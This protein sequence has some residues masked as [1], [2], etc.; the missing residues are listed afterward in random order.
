M[1]IKT[2]Y[3]AAAINRYPQAA[4]I[5]EASFAVFG[6]S[7]LVALWNIADE[8]G[9]G[10]EETLP[11]HEGLVTCIRFMSD[12]M[13]ASADDKGTLIS[14]RKLGSQWKSTGRIQ[15]HTKAISSLCVFNDWVITGSSDA[16]IRIWEVTST[17]ND[18][19][20]FVEFQT[21]PFQGKY[22]LSMSLTYLPQ[23]KVAILAI[24][25][26]GNSV[27]IWA[28]SD[29]QFVH[30]AV[31]TGH[32]DWVRGLA[33]L[34]PIAAGQPLV[35]AS[36]SQDATIRLWAFEPWIA[37]TSTRLSHPTETR[38]DDLL[39]AFEAS[40]GE[41]GDTEEGGRQISLRRHIITVKEAQRRFQR[42][43]ITFDA[44]LVGHE[45]GVTSLSWRPPSPFASVPTLLS[46]STDSS[47]IMWSPSTA[48][49]GSD[50][51]A[52]IWTN[53]QRFGDV[54][55]QR[56]GGFVGGVWNPQGDEILAWGWAGGWRRWR[57]CTSSKSPDQESW[58]E[59]ETISGHSGPVKS[60]GW[61]PDGRY[62]ISTG[63]DQST[64][65]HAPVL[66]GARVKPVWHEISRPQVHGYDML[67][68]VFIDPFKFVSIADE[69]VARVFEAP[70]GFMRLADS[71]GVSKM[72]DDEHFRPLGASVPPLGLSNKATEEGTLQTVIPEVPFGRRPFEGELASFTL[73]PETEKIFGHGY[74]S[75]TLTISP[76]KRLL[77]TACKASTSEHAV[78][79]IYDTN[80][81]QLVGQ[82]LEG[83][84]LTVTRIAF[85]PDDGFVLSVSRDRSWRL[86]ELQGGGYRP[87][88]ADK[89]HGRI[90]WD[91]AWAHES[92]VFATA[93]RDKTVKIWEKENES[94]WKVVATIRTSAAA[95]AVDF[96]PRTPE[97]RRR[98]A[99]GLETGDI[100]IYSNSH[101]TSS[102]NWTQDN[103][104]GS[105]V[106][107]VNQ[108][109][110]LAWQPTILGDIPTLASCSDDGTLR[111]LIVPIAMD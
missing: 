111:I 25:G 17:D 13:F 14:W 108:I 86:F 21:L 81:Y 95:T 6:S 89:S 5:S 84:L 51:L 37:E 2:A 42:F 68:A 72:P 76:S 87:V 55:G 103:I 40:L 31:L 85:S 35:L 107:H 47:V 28:R 49:S 52:P 110:R 59:V 78:V 75:I 99:I 71:L 61:S 90:I 19:D 44:L 50:R 83:H 104:V 100:L 38:S 23:T 92:D 11:G 79:R 53:R 9:H 73:W 27:Q 18:T 39:D 32:E 29:R 63:L 36:G 24:A 77:A 16:S 34:D 58:T 46:T 105:R 20:E 97:Y 64:R 96:S 43:S 56:L 109:N 57:C 98:L 66:T 45:A 22:P 91:C 67:G 41:L 62:I 4:A 3:I 106:A 93:S 80:K 65:I 88:A 82:P 69:K 70:R 74:E 101:L 102:A 26:T 10:V 33:F 54:G 12:V 8:S 1:R 94:E 15:A 7:N 60:V 30:A 48:L